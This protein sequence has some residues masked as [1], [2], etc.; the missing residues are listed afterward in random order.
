MNNNKLTIYSMCFVFAFSACSSTQKTKNIESKHHA[1]EIRQE[2]NYGK[3]I[4][5][6]IIRRY[7]VVK[8]DKAT[9]Y[10][11][12]V[13]KSIALFAGRSD[14]EYHFAI[15]DTDSINAFAAPGGYIFVTKGAV[16]AMQNESQL[17]AVLAH[18]IAHVNLKHI[19]NELPP[20]RDTEGII[21]RTSAVLSARGTLV[22]TAMDKIAEKA[23]QILFEKGLK[24]EAELEADQAALAYLAETGYAPRALPLYLERLRKI[25]SGKKVEKVYNT[26]P[27]LSKRIAALYQMIK[28][29][30]YPEK[31]PTVKD[32][33]EKNMGH[34]Q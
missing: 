29:N 32:R 10:L 18:E 28:D 17:A 20:P 27:P 8:D 30:K 4:A 14:F 23:I 3:T 13:G 12:Q 24:V 22:S 16:I 21:N 6:R 31:R 26:H 11:N 25:E 2:I 33:F 5:L 15:L 1:L 7:G 9:Y 34:L 19:L